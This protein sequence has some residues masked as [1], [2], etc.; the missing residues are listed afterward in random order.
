MTV[1]GKLLLI[2]FLLSAIWKAIEIPEAFDPYVVAQFL[3]A[4]VF[5]SSTTLILFPAGE[6]TP[7]GTA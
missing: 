1:T 5:F 4:S 3:S 2:V 6:Q 7:V